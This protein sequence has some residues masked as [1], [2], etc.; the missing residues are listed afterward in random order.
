MPVQGADDIAGVEAPPVQVYVELTGDG[1]GMMRRV[2]TWLIAT[3]IVKTLSNSMESSPFSCNTIIAGEGPESYENFKDQFDAIRP[4]MD[5]AADEGL[6]INGVKFIVTFYLG[7]DL[8][9]LAAIMGLVGHI[10]TFFCLWCLCTLDEMPKL[11][12][13]EDGKPT[14][15]RLVQLV[16]PTSLLCIFPSSADTRHQGLHA[17]PTQGTQCGI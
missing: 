16:Q 1:A 10:H 12:M 5:T 3:K 8:P 11:N 14:P 13:G 15:I 17:V 9:F 4:A 6:L 7:G 2:K